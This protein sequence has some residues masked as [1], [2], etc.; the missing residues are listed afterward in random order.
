M[1]M[2]PWYTDAKSERWINARPQTHAVEARKGKRIKNN[3]TH[4]SENTW[5][6]HLPADGVHENMQEKKVV[7]DKNR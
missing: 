5:M 4:T 1:Y 3:P 7:K 6:S 2:D